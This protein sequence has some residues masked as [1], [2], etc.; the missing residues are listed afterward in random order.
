MKQFSGEMD[1]QLNGSER[2]KRVSRVRFLSGF[3][4]K[5]YSTSVPR[6]GPLLS[7]L[8]AANRI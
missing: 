6:L 3:L 2:K 1:K 4:D 5:L 7:F 8:H